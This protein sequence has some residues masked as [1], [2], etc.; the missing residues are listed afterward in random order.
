[1]S[2]SVEAKHDSSNVEII[3]NVKEY[4][5][6]KGFVLDSFTDDPVTR[7][8]LKS[9]RGRNVFGVFASDDGFFQVENLVRGRR[10]RFRIEAP[11][12]VTTLSPQVRIPKKGDP[13]EPVF[14][15]GN[16]GSILGRVVLDR[17]GGMVEGAK[18]TWTPI[19]RWNPRGSIN[20]VGFT[21][22]DGHFLFEKLAPQK[23]SLKIE[24]S[25]YPETLVECGVKD[26]EITDLGDIVLKSSS[27]IRGTILDG[28]APPQP[29]PDKIVRL[30]S[31]DRP[32][33]LSLS[34]KT[35]PDGIYI[36]SQLPE[37]KY[38]VNPVGGDY[39]AEEI[40]LKAGEKKSLD[41]HP[42]Q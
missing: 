28:G 39:K 30:D 18:V 27:M 29:V 20:R 35:T 4:V 7:F 3:L 25:S 42:K 24:K 38:R 33:P 9:E 37:G 34:Y 31:I 1:V 2:K 12:Y 14:R 13:P 41:F 10:Y 15:I 26:G 5:T 36:F 21:G 19:G 8:T 11:G 32:V 40:E 16:G 17:G 23:Y 6:L 22:D